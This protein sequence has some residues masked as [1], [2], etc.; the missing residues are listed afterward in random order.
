MART[1]SRTSH[2]VSRPDRQHLAL[3]TL[4]LAPLLG[5]GE[6]P[7][8]APGQSAASPGEKAADTVYV[9][10]ESCVTCHAEEAAAHADSHHDLAMQPATPETV[11]G[12]FDDTTFEGPSG[13]TSFHRDGERFLVRTTGPDGETGTFPVRWV[14][15]VEPLQQVL[16][17]LEAGR[18]QCLTVAWDSDEQQWYDLYPDEPIAHDDTLHWSGRFQRWNTMCAACHSTDLVKRYEAADDSY[19]TTFAELDVSCEACHGPGSGHLAWAG[20]GLPADPMKGLT[21]LLRRDQPATQV[22][23]C[24]PCHS[25]RAALVDRPRPGLDLLDQFLPE[26][27]R[28]GL[29]FADGQIQDEVYVWGSFVQSKMHARG[30]ACSDCHDPHSLDLWVPGDAVCLQC[31]GEE[32]P[33]DRF[34]TLVAQQYNTPEHHHHPVDSEGARCVNCHMPERTYMGIDERRD[35]SLRIPRPDVSRAFGTPDVCTGCH[36]DRNLDWAVETVADWTGEEAATDQHFA[37]AL[38]AAREGSLGAD[39]ALRR[40]IEDTEHPPIVRSTALELLAPY[41]PRN[42][43][44]LE[45]ALGSEDALVRLGAARGSELLSATERRGLLLEHAGDPTRA[46]RAEVGRVLADLDPDSVRGPEA[47]ALDTALAEYLAAQHENGDMPASRLNLAVI[48]ERRSEPEKA[49]EE[50]RLALRQDERFLPARMNLS[51]LLAGSGRSI[52]ALPLLERG[53]ELHPDEAELHYSMGLLC[54]ELGE[55][56][57]SARH[58]TEAAD[59]M[60][61]RPRAQYNAALAAE[62]VGWLADARRCFQRALELSGEDPDV[63]HAASLFHARQSELE[64]ALALAR[65][66]VQVTRGAP[67]AVQL[68]QALERDLAN[69]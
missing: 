59:R 1:G 35:H 9:G 31:H 20:A 42:L 21:V 4:L 53:L 66:L 37:A 64:E 38:T 30:V 54:N 60:P 3:G 68:A 51:T 11:L 33:L 48:H 34:P 24:A 5:C 13:T 8:S 10:R 44:L 26:T 67:F 25:R 39:A 17:E 55:S 36:A 46:V 2:R 7:G 32:A 15:G 41:A 65:Q 19:D 14:F 47:E 52:E 28:E 45:D 6:E 22:E 23:T 40:V 49:E 50:Y 57:R 18:V 69:R 29:Y 43:D 62:Q 63:L 56:R 12:D 58:L 16:I 27:L 61:D